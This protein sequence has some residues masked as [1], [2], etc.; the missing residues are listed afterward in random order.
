MSTADRIEWLDTLLVALGLA[1][2][3]SR[4]GALRHRKREE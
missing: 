1:G 2:V 4:G 3:V